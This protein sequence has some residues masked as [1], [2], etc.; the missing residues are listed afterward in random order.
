MTPEKPI[1]S[2]QRILEEIAEKVHSIDRNVEEILDRLNDH[3]ADRPWYKNGWHQNGYELRS[4][5]DDD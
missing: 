5:D 3:F 4:N 2:G 1:R